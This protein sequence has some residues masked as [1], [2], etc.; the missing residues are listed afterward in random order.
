MFRTRLAGIVL[1]SVSL[2]PGC[3][4][5]CGDRPGICNRWA[6]RR[7]EATPVAMPAG[8]ECGGTVIPPGMPPQPYPYPYPNATFPGP[9]MGA[10]TLPPGRIPKAGIDEGKGKQFELEGASRTGPV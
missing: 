9:G 8:G 5:F 4:L 2:L 3:G 7:A 6:D 10:E 1:L